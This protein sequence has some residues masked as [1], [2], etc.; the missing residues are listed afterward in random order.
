VLALVV[1]LVPEGGA[2]RLPPPDALSATLQG[3]ALPRLVVAEHDPAATSLV[4]AA[5][6]ALS[7]TSRAA[8]AL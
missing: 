2:E 3:V 4:K 8:P 7:G 5:L 1:D 6:A